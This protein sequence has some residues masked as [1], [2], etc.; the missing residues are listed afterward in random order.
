MM[1]IKKEIL[2]GVSIGVLAYLYSQGYDVSPL[3]ILGG[4]GFVLY[5]ITKK[6]GFLKE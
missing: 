2:L 5:V 1:K 6:K 3:I 4:L